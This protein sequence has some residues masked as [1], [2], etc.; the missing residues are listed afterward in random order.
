[1]NREEVVNFVYKLLKATGGEIK[2]TMHI[3][4]GYVEFD[5][6]SLDKWIKQNLEI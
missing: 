5:K 3:S 4:E 2:T 1:M 6:P